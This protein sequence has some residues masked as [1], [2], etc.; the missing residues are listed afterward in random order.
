LDELP[1][2][3]E[4]GGN[5][6]KFFETLTKSLANASSGLVMTYLPQMDCLI[7]EGWE[8]VFENPEFSE[9]SYLDRFIHEVGLLEDNMDK[10]AG[11]VEGKI[12]VFIGEENPSSSEE[13]S[14]IITR[15]RF[16]NNER[17][18]V[19]IFGPARMQYQRNIS[20]LQ[21]MLKLLEEF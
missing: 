7:K 16:P 3:F 18:V 17:G 11:L 21:S 13:F 14:L 1:I 4:R 5:E 6:L 20:L 15:S 9:K 2:Q 12:N 8:E 10:I 19:A